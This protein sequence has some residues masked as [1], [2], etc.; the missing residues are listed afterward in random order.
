MKQPP[1]TWNWVLGLLLWSLLLG[2]L[3]ALDAVQD[4]AGANV[5]GHGLV[6]AQAAGACRLA[7]G[8]VA[9]AADVGGH[10]ARV[11]DGDR[12]AIGQQFGAQCFQKTIHREL[13]GAVRRAPRHPGQ[14]RERLNA[15][16]AAT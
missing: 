11:G 4:L 8:V 2:A 3:A 13:G 1:V 7:L 16:Q 14:A 10:H 15:H 6:F 9:S 5:D 12:H